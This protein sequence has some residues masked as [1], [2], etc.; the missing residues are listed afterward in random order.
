MKLKYIILLCII[1]ILA[2]GQKSTSAGLGVIYP[3]FNNQSNTLIN[4]INHSSLFEQV[5]YSEKPGLTID[6]TQ[7]LPFLFGSSFSIGG[8]LSW[9]NYDLKYRSVN[10]TQIQYESISNPLLIENS[11][12]NP[13]FSNTI[14]NA[15][16][17]INWKY[18]FLNG[19]I[20]AFGGVT[21]VIQLLNN[22]KLSYTRYITQNGS[23]SISVQTIDV[24][25]GFSSVLLML[26]LG[27]EYFVI[28]DLAITFN[29]GIGVTPLY[30]KSYRL[31]GNSALNI[32][33]LGVKY[34]IFR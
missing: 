8:G 10:L 28:D 23:E 16:I 5:T 17:P 22:Q 29:Y 6:I 3:L 27:C 13:S 7:D 25:N 26:N 33:S 18:P 2:F 24:H 34:C 14:L 19:S 31:V 9:I 21:T 12:I 1:P 32:F 11:A 30:E 20:N 4:N 15:I